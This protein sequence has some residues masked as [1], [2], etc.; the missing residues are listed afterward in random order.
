[1]TTHDDRYMSLRKL[2]DYDDERLMSYEFSDLGGLI[3]DYD[4]M[5][6]EI[7]TLR[8]RLEAAEAYIR[9]QEGITS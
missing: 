6:E 8:K 2:A 1:M 4:R 7:D 5:C 9:I 3:A